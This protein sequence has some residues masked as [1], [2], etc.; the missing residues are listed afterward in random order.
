MLTFPPALA[1]AL[2]AGATTLC[3]CWRLTRTDGAVLGFTNHDRDLAIAGTL[4]EAASGLEASRTE[5]RLGFAAGGGEVAGA[6]TSARLTE[7][8]ILRGLYDNAV[9]ET[10]LV[11]WSDPTAFA[12]LDTASI[13]EI[14][15]DDHGFTAE[16]R[17]PAHAWD[18]EQG[19]L[20]HATCP[21]E[22]GD[23]RC[24]AV[25][26][27]P[28]YR[29]TAAIDATDGSLTITAPAFSN[30]PT[31]WFTGGVLRV[32]SGGNAGA[33]FPIRDHAAD[34]IALW[35]PA[36]LALM[37]GDAAEATAGCDKR[38]ETCSTKFGNTLNFRGFPHIPT[39]D[40]VLRYANA[41]EGGHDG[42]A[43][44]D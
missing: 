8:D 36:P 37:A 15:R 27:S 31:G 22:L 12:L 11:D 21:A 13:G 25:L 42:R 4:Y 29:V 30:Y 35:R 1:A 40:Y 38:F 43:T 32:L 41:G 26:A 39:P 6:L 2:S 5:T 18:Q 9:V 33:S 10:L 24:K 19:R 16:L 7:T 23:G 44:T 14:R 3:R 34:R 17:G 20:F 28:T